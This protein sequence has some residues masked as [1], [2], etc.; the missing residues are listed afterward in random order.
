MKRAISLIAVGLM[1][2]PCVF[3]LSACKNK[4][5]IPTGSYFRCDEAGKVISDYGWE[6]KSKTACQIESGAIDRK[7]KYSITEVEGQIQFNRIRPYQ[8]DE[9]IRI[10]FAEYD[11]ET[12]ILTVR[13]HYTPPPS[14]PKYGE[15]E[16]ANQYKKK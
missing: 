4:Y 9:V 5:G 1:L 6:I 8:S 16:N 15:R 14:R 10:Y 3:L 7:N 2:V 12:K 13:Y 11:S